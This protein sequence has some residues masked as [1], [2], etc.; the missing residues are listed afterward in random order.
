MTNGRDRNEKPPYTLSWL[1]WLLGGAVF[2]VYLVTLNRSLSFLPDWTSVLQQPPFGAKLAGWSFI[3][4]M[5]A[6]VYHFLTLPLRLLPEHYIPVALNLFSA[7]CAA[8]ALGQLARCVALLP[9]DRTRDQRER[10][11]SAEGIL[12]FSWAWL[13][14][15]FATVVCALGLSMWEHG[16]NGTPEMLDLLLFAYVLRQ[17]LEFRGDEK[18]SRL[19]RAALV[20]GAAITNNFAMIGFFP[21]FIAAL[22]WTRRLAFFKLKFLGRMSLCGLAGLSFYFWLPIVN[23]FSGNDSVG[24]WQTVLSNLQAQKWLLSSVPRYTLLLLCLTSVLPV[25][26]LAIRWSSQFGDPSRHGVIV[27]TIAFH[28]CH[29]LILIACVWTALDPGFSPR[30]VSFGFAYLPLYFLGALSIGYYSGY[31][32]LISRAIGDRYRGPGQ[33]A[34]LIQRVTGAV[35]VL[36]FGAVTAIL[37]HRNTP[38]IRLT[39][40]SLNQELA[41][42]LAATLPPNGIILSD[43]PRRL[44][45]VQEHLASQG[46]AKDYTFLL[47][48]WMPSA[49]YHEFLQHRHPHWN[50]P[51]RPEDEKPISDVA[52]VQLL[53]NLAQSNTIT[54]LHPSFGYYFEYFRTEPHGLTQRLTPYPDNRLLAPPLSPEVIASNQK[55]WTEAS[56]TTLAQLIPATRYRDPDRKLKPLEK[57]YKTIGLDLDAN[58]TANLM[59][60]IYARS[61]VSW[62]VELHKAGDYESAAPWLELATELNPKNVVAEINLAFNKK[63]RSGAPINAEQTQSV[64]EAFGESRS[65]EQVLT[66]NGPYDEPSLVFGQ[67]YVFFRGNLLRQAAQCFDRVRTV[68]TNDVASRLWLGQL[69]LNRNYPDLTL[70]MAREVRQIASRTPGLATNLTDLFTLEA[71]AYL[72]KKEDDTAFNLIEQNLAKA[73]RNF[74]LLA[75][76]A[77]VYGDN[78]RHARA[79]EITERMLK[80]DPKN[81]ACWINKGCFEI[82]LGQLTNAITSFDQVLS[83]EATN[84]TAILYRAIANLR[85]EQYDAAIADYEQVQRQFPTAF[86]VDYGL[87]EIAY[88]RKD[89]N[90]AIRHYEAYLTHAPPG[91][92]ETKFI[93][94]R[95]QEL[96]G[97]K[98]T[99]PKSD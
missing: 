55:F 51:P 34:I 13:P 52:L 96:K 84:Y 78:G 29:I 80:L 28:L 79:L 44:W 49:D 11:K 53:L 48:Q 10:L 83:L 21:I 91:T 61:L 42:S 3:P 87:G 99:P 75:A 30:Q 93:A 73:P 31:L 8:L 40:G 70:E 35:M 12:T 18:E 16:T 5:L 92:A 81:L 62:A 82:E 7:G 41:T 97:A 94:D 46:R 71:A 85:A 43:E 98:P 20:Y 1:P 19:Y 14:P 25:F 39:N 86:Q 9:H 74:N 88:R 15:V 90:T 77:K 66:L 69:Q 72:A 23:S 45:I 33:G 64:E 26:L 38:E 95:I 76:A 63:F 32:L 60:L 6:P 24:F 59:G 56:E 57:F 4:E 22:V 68:A 36:F 67:A 17:L 47:S 27:T 37:L 54:Y 65:W 2:V 89:T 58:R 50:P